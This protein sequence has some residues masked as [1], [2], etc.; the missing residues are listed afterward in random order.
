[1]SRPYATFRRYT[2]LDRNGRKVPGIGAH[3]G[4]KLI[5]HLTDE[6]ALKLADKLVDLTEKQTHD[7]PK[8]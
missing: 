6:E 5:L 2:W 8:I 4:G 7:S 1:M 3:K